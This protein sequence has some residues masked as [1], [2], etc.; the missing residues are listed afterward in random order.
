VWAFVES[1]DDYAV[2]PSTDPAGRSTEELALHVESP[3]AS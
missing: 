2:T 1:D 3:W